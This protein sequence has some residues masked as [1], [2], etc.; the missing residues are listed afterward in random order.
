M[1]EIKKTLGKVNLRE[2]NFQYLLGSNSVVD[3]FKKAHSAV[4]EV[5]KEKLKLYSLTMYN[6]GR[7]RDRLN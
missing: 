4:K 7:G 3:I 6:D 2:A 1:A 5:A